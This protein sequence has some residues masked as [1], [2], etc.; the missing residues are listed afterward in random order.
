MPTSFELACAATS[1]SY[2]SPLSR[3]NSGKVVLPDEKP[4]GQGSQSS[5]ETRDALSGTVVSITV[6]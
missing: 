1:K 5:P 4:T 3:T 2:K 6:L